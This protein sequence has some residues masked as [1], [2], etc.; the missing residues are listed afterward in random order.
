MPGALKIKI[1]VLMSHRIHEKKFNFLCLFQDQE[2]KTASTPS[3]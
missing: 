3:K 1:D 2:L